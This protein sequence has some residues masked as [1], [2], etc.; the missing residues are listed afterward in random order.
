MRQQTIDPG[1]AITIVATRPTSDQYLHLRQQAGW[2]GAD[3]QATESG[4]ATSL[5]VV[6]ALHDNLVVGCARIIGD[7]GLYFYIQ[8]MLVDEDYRGAG[9]G[10]RMMDALLDWLR[11]NTRPGAFVG[12]MAAEGASEYYRRFGFEDRPPGRPGMVLPFARL[13]SGMD[14]SPT[15]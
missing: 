8:D 4:L 1:P 13:Q 3:T 14:S 15:K 11:K 9:T 7:G 5:Y 12:L 2:G 10:A 6:C